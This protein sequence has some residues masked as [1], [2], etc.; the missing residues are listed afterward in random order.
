MAV[1]PND[2]PAPNT[3]DIERR[4]PGR[5]ANAMT[6]LIPLMRGDVPDEATRGSEDETTENDL[7]SA[8]GVIISCIVGTCLWII[9]I[10]VVILFLRL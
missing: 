1:E 8:S 3:K 5:I 9:L 2:L 6:E 10:G 7:D 4:R